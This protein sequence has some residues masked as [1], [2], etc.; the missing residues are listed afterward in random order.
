MPLKLP[1]DKTYN[2][3]SHQ[4]QRLFAY[5]TMPVVISTR[6]EVLQIMMTFDFENIVV[7]LWENGTLNI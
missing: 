6:K 7:S 3:I 4:R 1:T 2:G 5:H